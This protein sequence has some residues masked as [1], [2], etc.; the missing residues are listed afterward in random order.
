MLNFSESR[1]L[2]ILGANIT[3]TPNIQILWIPS[4]SGVKGNDK[5][6]LAANEIAQSDLTI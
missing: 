4:H 3:I 5:A 2:Q 1:N 6:H